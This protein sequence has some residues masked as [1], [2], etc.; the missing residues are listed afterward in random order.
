M[1]LDPRRLHILRAVALRGGV[2]DASRLLNLTPSAVSQQLAL[3]EREAG[4]AL[5]DRS[6]R[7]VALTAAGQT[8]AKRA[9][10]IEQELAEAKRELAALSGRVTGPVTI[11]GFST[12]IRHLMVPTFQRLA[13]TQ[14]GLKPHVIEEVDEGKALRE[15]RTGG[16][17]LVVTEREDH[18]PEPQYH[19]LLIHPLAD[20][21]YRILVPARWTPAPDNGRNLA[22]LPWI[23]GPPE[24]G[25][26]QALARLAE[27]YQ[28]TPKIEHVCIEFPAMLTLVAAGM[29]AAILPSLALAGID[30]EQVAVSPIPSHCSRRLSAVFRAPRFCPEPTVDILVAELDEAAAEMGFSIRERE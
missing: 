14:P 22:P 7:R 6:Q 10:A 18:H 29:G 28:F 15:L 9:E 4:V 23:A 16:V 19:D 20:D 30:P 26:G 5:I 12:A 27:E 17:D 24:S 25:C 1:E 11:A 2:T 21:D 3:L 13:R 8:L